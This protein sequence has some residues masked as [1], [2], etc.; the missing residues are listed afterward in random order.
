MDLYNTIHITGR[1]EGKARN[2][3]L[4]KEMNSKQF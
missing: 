3:D 2:L 4:D 1:M